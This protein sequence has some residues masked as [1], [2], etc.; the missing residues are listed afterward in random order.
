M[1]RSHRESSHRNQLALE[2]SP[3]QYIQGCVSSNSSCVTVARAWGLRSD[4]TSNRREDISSV[5]KAAISKTRPL[6]M[7]NLSEAPS[8]LANDAGGSLAC[9]GG[10]REL[11]RARTQQRLS[12]S[13]IMTSFAELYRILVA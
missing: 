6:S 9:M 7:E 13:R 10:V 1:W 8:L 4:G 12:P 5:G 3:L 2:R 11:W